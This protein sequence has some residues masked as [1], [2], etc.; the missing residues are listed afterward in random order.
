VV[1][2]VKKALSAGVSP[3]AIGVFSFSKAAATELKD[4]IDDNRMSHV[5]TIH[6]MAYGL[7]R[8]KPM[9]WYH[10]KEF[11]EKYGYR[12]SGDMRS[13]D[14]DEGEDELPDDSLRAAYQGGVA[15][16]LDLS[17]TAAFFD[18]S[19]SRSRTSRRS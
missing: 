6:S 17:A 19:W 13:E 1:E 4:R 10:W 9:E 14:D 2:W 12:L 18:E 8:Y 7:Q 11:G 16:C 5:R 15:R 3:N